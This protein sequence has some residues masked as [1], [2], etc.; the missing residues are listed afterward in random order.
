MY[1]NI[2]N[3]TPNQITG[4]DE[5]PLEGIN[6]LNEPPPPS[7]VASVLPGSSTSVSAV[8]GISGVSPPHSSTQDSVPIIIEDDSPPP[9]RSKGQ[10]MQQEKP[11]DEKK[12]QQKSHSKSRSPGGGGGGS[13]AKYSSYESSQKSHSKSRSPRT[14]RN[15][16]YDFVIQISQGRRTQLGICPR[17]AHS[18]LK[19]EKSAISK[20]QKHIICIFKNGKKSIFA[21]EKSL[22]LPKMQF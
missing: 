11:Y 9:K 22:K 10:Q 18:A 7:A 8:V 14:S 6:P 5:I 2:N 1:S 12:G 4:L 16:Y 21:T 15:K 13:R 19:V 20:V 3:I 17:P